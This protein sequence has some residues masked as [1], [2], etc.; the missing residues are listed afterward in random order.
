MILRHAVPNA[1]HPLVAYQGIAFP[2][3]LT[4]EIEVAIVFTL[5]TVGPAIIGAMTVG[6]VYVT[7]SFVLMLAAVLSSAT[8]C[9]HP[10]RADRSAHPPR[11]ERCSRHAP[12]RPNNPCGRNAMTKIIGRNRMM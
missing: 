7:G 1:L 3:M 5:A 2:Y 12:T 6:D 10:P 8:H 11:R 4:G 9:R